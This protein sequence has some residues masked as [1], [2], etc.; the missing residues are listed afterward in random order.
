MAERLGLNYTG[1]I[2]VN[3]KAKLRGIISSIKPL[4]YKIRQTDFRI[5]DEIAPQALLE[6]DK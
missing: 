3:V 2:G 4:L 5:S 6:A 1:T